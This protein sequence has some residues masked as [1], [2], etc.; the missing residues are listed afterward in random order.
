MQTAPRLFANLKAGI[1]LLFLAAGVAAAA[2][3]DL[4][5]NL[6]MAEPA[7]IIGA[8]GLGL[9]TVHIFVDRTL[10][11]ARQREIESAKEHH[12]EKSGDK[13]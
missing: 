1:V 13:A 3:L 6:K 10:H 5:H 7:A 2:Y 4:W 12:V 9:V 11:R 8:I